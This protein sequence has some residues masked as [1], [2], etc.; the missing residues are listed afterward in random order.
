MGW[1]TAAAAM[2]ARSIRT[3]GESVTFSP[4]A[5]GGP[6]TIAFAVFDDDYQA[7][8]PDTGVPVSTGKPALGVLLADLPTS[9][10]H[11][12]TWTVRG[13]AYDCVDV[14]PDSEGVSI[15]LLHKKP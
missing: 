1:K 10:A 7:V 14:Q 9:P 11:G 12:D 15:L 5:G 2:S 3:F 8:D 4:K 13:Q 6:H